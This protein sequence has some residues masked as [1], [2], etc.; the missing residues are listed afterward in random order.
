MISGGPAQA[1]ETRQCEVELFVIRVQHEF[2]KQM[3]LST[4]TQRICNVRVKWN[5]GSIKIRLPESLVLDWGRAILEAVRGKAEAS[6]ESHHCSSTTV[7]F[8]GN[9]GDIA[10]VPSVRAPKSDDGI[11]QLL[12]P[13]DSFAYRS[14]DESLQL[15]EMYGSNDQSIN[16]AKEQEMQPH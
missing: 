9:V 13:D 5:F 12:D 1:S 14:D 2:T 15:G 7:T 10:P 8:D 3:F 16:T 6:Y 11:F 4:T